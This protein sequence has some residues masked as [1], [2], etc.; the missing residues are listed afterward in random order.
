MTITNLC[1]NHYVVVLLVGVADTGLLAIEGA[2]QV[3]TVV[4][5]GL[6]TDIFTPQ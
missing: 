2:W 4:N 3:T 1:C 5:V 6:D